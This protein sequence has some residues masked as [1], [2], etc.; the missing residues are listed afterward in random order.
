[1][2]QGGFTIRPVVPADQDWVRQ[3]TIEEWGAEIIVV[4]SEVFRPAE[5][6]GFAAELDGEIVGL[7]TYRVAEGECEIMTLNSWREGLGVGTALLSAARQAAGAAL[8]LSKGRAGCG[9]LYLVTTNDNTHALRFYQKRGFTICAVRLNIMDES[10]K[11]KPEI[12]PTGEDGIP[13]RDEI[14]LEIEL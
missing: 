5:L 2:T 11:I 14:E 1:M 13:I 9:R 6:P 3:K 4:H 12:P 7:L 10:R 8:S